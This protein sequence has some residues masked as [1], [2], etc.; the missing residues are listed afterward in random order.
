[1]NISGTVT[2]A[3]RIATMATHSVDY[4]REETA[5]NSVLSG[6]DSGL[7]WS[8][9]FQPFPG[10]EPISP[11]SLTVTTFGLEHQSALLRISIALLSR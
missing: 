5:L 8:P 3:Y 4:S 1:M 10:L 11:S 2:S 6:P 9:H 7:L